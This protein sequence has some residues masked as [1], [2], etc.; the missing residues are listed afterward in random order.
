MRGNF[1]WD[2]AVAEY[3]VKRPRVVPRTV[4]T[5]QQASFGLVGSD[6]IKESPQSGVTCVPIMPVMGA[7]GRR[8]RF[9]LATLNETGRLDRLNSKIRNNEAISIGTS[10]PNTAIRELAAIGVRATLSAKYIE[11]GCIEALPK[12]YPEIDAVFEL[13][14]SG[15]SLAQNGL[16]LVIDEINFIDLMKIDKA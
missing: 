3:F 10:Y 7:D 11:P 8:L 16:K 6:V 15:D 5:E 4:F 1:I 12:Q 13:V 9:G 2:G 14:Q